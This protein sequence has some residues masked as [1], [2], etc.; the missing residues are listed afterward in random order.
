MFSLGIK[1]IWDVASLGSMWLT[2]K[3]FLLAK[4][5]QV[6]FSFGKKHK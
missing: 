4:S 5:H 1:E 3:A 2:P 6:G